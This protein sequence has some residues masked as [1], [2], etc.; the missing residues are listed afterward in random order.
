[1]AGKRLGKK[2]LPFP[3]ETAYP[4]IGKEAVSKQEI[5]LESST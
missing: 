3:K 4:P 1:M 5:T 2:Y